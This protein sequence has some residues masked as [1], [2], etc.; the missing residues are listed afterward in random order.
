MSRAPDLYTHKNSDDKSLLRDA[1][2]TFYTYEG[3]RVQ[4]ITV[5]AG[6]GQRIAIVENEAGEQY[7][8]PWEM[9]R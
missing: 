6:R 8:V 2:E 7:D 4:L 5:L 1:A 9:L 3:E